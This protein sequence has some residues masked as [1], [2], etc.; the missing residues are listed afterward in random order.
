[1]KFIIICIIFKCKC[2]NNDGALRLNYSLRIINNEI[3]FDFFF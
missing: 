1:M 2:L 3:G